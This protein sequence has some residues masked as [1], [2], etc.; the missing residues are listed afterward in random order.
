M[1]I[2]PVVDLKFGRVA[3]PTHLC[4]L[5][6]PVWLGLRFDLERSPCLFVGWRVRHP[7]I[8][9]PRT[10]GAVIKGDQSN[11]LAKPKQ[12]LINPACHLIFEWISATKKDGRAAARSAGYLVARV[13]G[14]FGE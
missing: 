8:I 6:G 7:A 3:L 1:K 14:D 12:F 11:V 13:L 2:L 10:I 5:V 9:K 4:W